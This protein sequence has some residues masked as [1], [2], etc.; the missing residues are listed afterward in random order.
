MNIIQKNYS[1]KAL[2]DLKKQTEVFEKRGMFKE[3]FQLSFLI[4]KLKEAK[5]FYIPTNGR[6]F[7]DELKGLKD[8]KGVIIRLPFSSISVEF[9]FGDEYRTPGLCIAFDT[10][11]EILKN[12]LFSEIMFGYL[13]EDLLNLDG[14]FI[15]SI[16]LVF[17][18]NGKWTPN[19]FISINDSNSFIRYG[20][21]FLDHRINDRKKAELESEGNDYLDWNSRPVLELIECLSCNN[22]SYEPI[23]KIKESTNLKRI[24][25]GKLPIYETHVLF[26]EPGK[27][28]AKSKSEGVSAFK[29]SP[30]QHLRRG[31]IRR[32]EG[33]KIWVNQCVVGL[34]KNGLIDKSYLI[35][36]PTFGGD[37]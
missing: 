5:K 25:A 37:K 33:K 12:K 24:K 23:Q 15:T 27:A 8:D 19:Y 26:I 16:L 32:L 2:I 10:P 6:I 4:T 3:A 9:E 20:V 7:D 17:G 21:S 30:R 13:H 29:K 36:P 11:K 18:S 35:T 22:V 28:F 31:H 14:P 1:A 34:L